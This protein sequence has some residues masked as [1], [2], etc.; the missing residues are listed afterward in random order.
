[1]PLATGAR[2]G[3]Y[4]IQA[5]IGAGGMGEVYRGRDTR[6]DR[7]V[8]IK[9]LPTHLSESAELK[10]RFEREARAISALTHPH[11]CSLY[12]LGSEGGVEFLVMEFLEGETLADRL[13]RGRIPTDQLLRWATE[14]ADAMD[15]AH[16]Q[17][18]VH[19]DLKP[20]NIMLTKSGVKLLD[21]GLAKLRPAQDPVSTT[22]LSTLQTEAPAAPL[23]ERGMV[24]G[25]F[26]YMAPEQLEGREADARSDIFSFGAVLYEMATG[27]KAFSAK[28]RASLIA[29]ILEHEPP[30]ISSVQPLIPPALDRVVRTCLA[31]DPED[32]WQTAHD[33]EGEL[34]WIA[35]VG[36]QAGVAAPVV[37]K[38]KNRE[39]LAWA[40]FAVATIAAAALAAAWLSR[41]PR[42]LPAVRS[43]LALPQNTILG[44]LAVSPDGTRLTFTASSPGAQPNL[45]IRRLDG[46][47]VERLPGT[48]GAFFPFWSPDGR[49]VAFFSEGKL[50]RIDPSSGAVLT[51]CE[52]KRGTGGTWNR[53]GTIVFGPEPTS[54]LFRVSAAGGQPVS[55]TKLDASRKETAHR[56]PSFLPD[57]RHFLYMAA[58]LAAPPGDPANSIRIGSLDG[59]TDK[60]VVNVASEA[61]YA[62]GRL[63]YVKD[64]SL[65][66]REFD[67]SRLE[68]K[69]EPTPVVLRLGQYGWQ[70][71]WPFSVSNNGVLV[72]AP[73]FLVPSRLLWFDRTGKQV[74]ETGQA[75]LIA[76]P[77]LS[78]DARRIA[79]DVEDP[80]RDSTEV[81]IYEV[82]NGAGTK[83]V[84]SPAHDLTPVWSPDGSRIAFA[85]DRKSKGARA[86]IWVKPLD[87]SREENLG[88][89]EDDRYPE[90]WSP[91]GRYI[92][93]DVIQARGQ[94]NTQLWIFDTAERRAFPFAADG[95]NS[96]G[97]RFSPD[98]RYI[99]YH[100][101]ESGSFEVY[102]RAFPGP[103]GK[104]QVSTAGGGN[105]VWSRDGKELYYLSG[106][107]KI[108]AVPVSQSGGFHAGAPAALLAVH[109]SGFRTIYDVSRDGRFLV[110]SLPA[111]QGSPP[112]EVVV[113]WTSLLTKS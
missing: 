91:D 81:W 75:G 6:L 85:S 61:H 32:R 9:V 56:Y 45:W 106:D 13:L 68:V 80:A 76:D 28:S 63:F 40:G 82:G 102:V 105:P 26:Q 51:I 113:N 17:G 27:Q 96:S 108:V 34:K 88:E 70:F 58:N 77:R 38:R 12:D 21:F 30:A 50:K 78:P 57:G 71:F 7:T 94:R 64:G 41:A 73:A 18:I 74:G 29:A 25:T 92:S 87:G 72:A 107:N 53:E 62:S 19:R 33:L 86:D 4:E 79:V 109:P 47:S 24:L 110:N 55:L 5:P 42:R 103:G 37:A 44:E 60:A 99:A 2:L 46:S 39:R 3:P 100:S 65:L 1:M 31:K 35:Q 90:D 20:G 67:P 69:G 8:A 36:S 95:L 14:I 52:A 11:I 83:V 16:R 49:F 101:D 10:Q 22:G 23:T 97:S 48:G 111:D 98:G 89:S 112:L 54:G 104:W 66:A 43:T 84:F 93:F 59:K 15:K